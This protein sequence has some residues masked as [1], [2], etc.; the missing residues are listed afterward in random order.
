MKDK[1]D[2]PYIIK[3][4]GGQGALLCNDCRVIIAT[5][6]THKKVKHYC[7]E[8]KKKRGKHHE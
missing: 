7:E 8:C 3:F 5:G 1:I 4:N 6:F 2:T